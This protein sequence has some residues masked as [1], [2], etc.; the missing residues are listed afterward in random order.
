[1][2]PLNNERIA[3]VAISSHSTEVHGRHVDC[4]MAAVAAHHELR[5]IHKG[6]S[7]MATTTLYR[8]LA[9][10]SALISLIFVPAPESARTSVGSSVVCATGTCCLQLNATC[11]AGG[12]TH[13]GY[14]YQTSG[15]CGGS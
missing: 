1:M 12:P 11:N 5:V 4:Y 15:A 2:K 6:R 8:P 10:A 9:L 3:N 13:T 14:Y 7:R